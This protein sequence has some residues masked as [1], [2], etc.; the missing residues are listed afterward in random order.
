[1]KLLSTSLA[2]LSTAFCLMNPTVA[3]AAET[4]AAPTPEEGALVLENDFLK[5]VVSPVGA[6][7]VSLYDKIRQREEVKMLSY[8]GGMNE[9]RFGEVLNLDDLKDRY[10]LSLSEDDAGS[11][12][13]KATIR[14]K[15]TGDHPAAATVVKSYTLPADASRIRTALEIANEGKERIGIIPWVR[16][17]INRGEKEQPE[18]AHMT[19][20]GAFL[21]GRPIPGNPSVGEAAANPEVNWHFFPAGN[22]SSR[23]VLPV[24]DGS[25]TF[26]TVL[27]PQDMFK[28]FNWHRSRENFATHEV[29]SAPMFIQP[30]ESR[31][32]EYDLIVAEP[33]RNLVY[34][35]PDLV[36]GA[37]P[38]PTGISADT[39]KLRL[40]F[41]ATREIAP[42]R[43]NVEWS[44]AAA[45]A[46]RKSFALDLAGLSPSTTVEKTVEIDL[47]GHEI[48]SLQLSFVLD[49]KAY[50]PGELAEDRREVVI[51]LV[52]D[53][54]N[55]KVVYPSRSGG[56]A[57]LPRIAARHRT[58][59]RLAEGERFAAYGW[60]AGLRFFREDTI[61][62]SGE[63]F[64]LR[65]PAGGHASFQLIL[66]PKQNRGLQLAVKGG[67]LKGPGGKEV[68]CE[69]V[70]E[71]FDVPTTV[72]SAYNATFAV[73]DYPEGLLPVEKTS[74]EGGRNRPLFVTYRVPADAPPGE[75]RGVVT[76]SENGVATEIPVSM[77]VWNIQLPVRNRWMDTPSSLKGDGGILQAVVEKHL[78]YRLT[79]CDAGV[80]KSLLDLRFAEFEKEFEPYIAAGATKVFLGSIPDLLKNHRANLPEVESYLE[81]KGW[82]DYFYVRPGFD[83]ASTDLVL[84]IREVCRQWK[85]LSKVPVME[86][87]YHDEKASE[88]YG[89]LDI[90]SRSLSDAPWIKERMAAGDRFWKVNAFQSALEPEP[91]GIRRTYLAFW[92]YSFTG[93]YIWTVKQWKGVT[94]WGRD[95]WCD[96][97]TGNLAAVLMWPHGEVVLSTIRLEALRA[98]I[99]DNMLFWML[100][101]KVE[102]LKGST[103]KDP[104]H[105]AA[106]KK[107]VEL[108][109]SGRLS[110]RAGSLDELEQLRRQAGETLS[111]L[112]T[113]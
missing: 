4:S 48:S 37:S 14:V 32:R 43:A 89:S 30:G 27:K 58:A 59:P 10:T 50:F 21:R 18:E 99:E 102:Q 71:F 23:V 90:Y 9:V 98:A 62:P 109:N 28:I 56:A 25:N 105:V 92:D 15:P 35:S 33:V 1:M 64:A 81:K 49:G 47:T 76:V 34:A 113:L 86:T 66:S 45:P 77:T 19:E 75:Y 93:T 55:G 68:V 69:S 72:P 7:I 11:R 20:Y 40:T 112:N 100:R 108:C 42:F 67:D 95:Y 41:G 104:A 73:G 85:A 52:T 39:K 79:P 3:V 54:A 44:S 24:E 46:E 87:Y 36:I 6:R 83:E 63:A 74:L 78:Q 17:L 107:G 8:V 2:I 96:A 65:S 82:S 16:N 60:P 5:V 97:G 29:I 13:V 26:A 110:E 70:N 53:P 51:P 88:L 101:E 106:L 84:E 80:V 31:R 57:Q 61:E 22:W 111:V 12:T 38:H 91:W 94:D 103:P